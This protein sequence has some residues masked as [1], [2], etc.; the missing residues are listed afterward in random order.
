MK[1][2]FLNFQSV[3]LIAA[4]IATFSLFFSCHPKSKEKQIISFK[5]MKPP[6]TGVINESAKTIIVQ[7][8]EDTDVTALVPV[9]T[10][11][12]LA[13]VSP[14]SGM[15][16]D[17]TNPVV[18]TVTAENESTVKYTVTVTSDPSGGGGGGSNET[19]ELTSPITENTTLKDLGLEI[20][21]IYKGNSPLEVTNSATL[22]IKPGVTIKFVYE[23]N[24][25]GIKITSGATIIA[26]GTENKHI[27]FI[28]ANNT[29]GSWQGIEIKSNTNNQFTYCDFLNMGH[30][31]RD[32]Y[33]GL[34]LNTGATVGV[35]YCKFT[36]GKGTGI[37]VDSYGGA[38]QFTVF[39]H[40]VFEGYESFPPVTISDSPSLLEKFDMS[41]DFTNNTKKYIKIYPKPV[42]KNVTIN[43]TTVPYYFS[44][45][46]QNLNYTLTINEGVTVYVERAKD[47]IASSATQNACLVINGTEAKKVT[48]TRLPDATDYWNGI[49]LDKMKGCVITNCIVAYGGK[50]SGA[51]INLGSS[52][53]V[54]LRNVEIKNA[55]GYG[56]KFSNCDYNLTH[57]N[58]TFANNGKG[59]V[60][61]CHGDVLNGLP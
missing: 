13:S 53:E 20:D 36:N 22:T 26:R 58:V 18:Y 10:V 19:V 27:Q 49:Y 43:Q 54:T 37:N 15:P 50:N 9:I 55:E 16:Q 47:L 11:S 8:P 12:D 25:G 2:K 5:I 32:D 6:A 35:S 40:N 31:E 23:G 59:N 28:G 4:C 30:T 44:N 46:I 38:C 24:T 7:V 3:V 45:E 1:S 17:F 14:A 56:I 61:D 57:T 51:M 33:G 41:S 21:Y 39:S 29:K 42:T 34:Q 48:I 60:L 52:S